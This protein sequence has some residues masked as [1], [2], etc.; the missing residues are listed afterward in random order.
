MSCVGAESQM[1]M[2][3]RKRMSAEGEHLLLHEHHYIAAGHISHPTSSAKTVHR[4]DSHGHMSSDGMEHGVKRCFS[5]TGGPVMR[6]SINDVTPQFVGL[7]LDAED[8]LKKTHMLKQHSGEHEVR[9][10][11]GGSH[12]HSHAHIVQE[13]EEPLKRSK[14]QSDVGSSVATKAVV[15]E[16]MPSSSSGAEPQVG[17]LISSLQTLKHEQVESLLTLLTIVKQHT[18]SP[19]AADDGNQ[20]SSDVVMQ[21]AHC[22]QVPSPI[23][24]QHKPPQQQSL[25]A[26]QPTVHNSGLQRVGSAAGSLSSMYA[27]SLCAQQLQKS[28]HSG[29]PGV[30]HGN[31]PGIQHGGSPGLPH[32]ASMPA[33]IA[34]LQQQQPKLQPLVV[35]TGG[36]PQQVPVTPQNPSSPYQPVPT[37]H[38]HRYCRTILVLYC[39]II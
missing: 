11:S 33:G 34:N 24:F 8:P 22:K 21:K 36:S 2:S 20:G 9:E 17:A 14:Y 5:P 1:W 13:E 15:N 26:A 39:F 28:V 31:S 4:V 19:H 25:P 37:L 29:S 23:Q 38:D 16:K 12:G 18:A 10:T 32:P 27:D 35:P 6:M 7:N 3:G 30:Q